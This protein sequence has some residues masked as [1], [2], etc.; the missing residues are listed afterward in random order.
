MTVP[1]RYRCPRCDAIATLERRASL[2][3][4]AVTPYPLEGWRYA[5]P[6]GEFESADGVRLV[7]GDHGEAN[8]C[9]EPFYLS[10]VRFEDGEEVEPEPEDE[11]VTLSLGPRDPWQPRR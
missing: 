7:C 5:D 9:G 6:D 11:R 4:K 1:V 10:F 8:G 2:A 3:D